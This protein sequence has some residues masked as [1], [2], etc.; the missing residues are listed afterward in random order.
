M[1]R[2]TSS[3]RSCKVQ[4]RGHILRPWGSRGTVTLEQKEAVLARAE[5]AWSARGPLQ[6]LGG[7]HP[8]GLLWADNSG[9]QQRTSG[10]EG[11]QAAGATLI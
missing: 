3:G 6:G 10:V 9:A 5:G 7:E 2:Q 1:V 8:D 4:G 11:Q